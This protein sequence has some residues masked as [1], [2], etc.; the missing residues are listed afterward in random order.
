MLTGFFCTVYKVS[1]AAHF[2]PNS[3]TD[4][5]A[6]TCGCAQA[7]LQTD[8]VLGGRRSSI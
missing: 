1:T 8:L 5:L 7:Q 4:L 3:Q 2:V 6:R